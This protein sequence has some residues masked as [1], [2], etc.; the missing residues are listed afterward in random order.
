MCGLNF[1]PQS[2]LPSGNHS[3]RKT[4]MNVYHEGFYKFYNHQFPSCFVLIRTDSY[5]FVL[6][7]ESVPKTSIALLFYNA[8]IAPELMK[9]L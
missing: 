4:I 2:L 5:C 1:H 8:S 7:A 6:F 3:H 9:A